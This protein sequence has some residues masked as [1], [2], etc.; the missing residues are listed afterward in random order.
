MKRT[1]A[2]EEIS[3]IWQIAVHMIN[4]TANFSDRF[5]WEDQGL[6]LKFRYH[7]GTSVFW[8]LASTHWVT[9]INGRQTGVVRAVDEKRFTDDLLKATLLI[10]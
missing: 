7:T 2:D 10:G 5:T 9:Q 3:L 8:Y 6:G 1:L 4:E